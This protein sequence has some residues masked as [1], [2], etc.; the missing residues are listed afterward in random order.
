MLSTSRSSQRHHLTCPRDRSSRNI[1]Y[2]DQARAL[3]EAPIAL[4]PARC[5]T[6]LL[7]FAHTGYSSGSASQRS[8]RPLRSGRV[9]RSFALQDKRPALL[10]DALPKMVQTSR[11][12]AAAAV[13]VAYIASGVKAQDDCVEPTTTPTTTIPTPTPDPCS[14]GLVPNYG[15]CGVR[16]DPLAFRSFLLTSTLGRL[17]PRLHQMCPFPAVQSDGNM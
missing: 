17:L 13:A 2:R 6:T 1:I 12:L 15:Q 5:G 3:A 11:V 8:T 10:Q 16:D 4:Q 7:S 14:T 9:A